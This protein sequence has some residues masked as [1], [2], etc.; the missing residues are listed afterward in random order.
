MEQRISL[1]TLGVSS[2]TES[3]AFHKRLGW[4]AHPTSSDGIVFFQA[5]GMIFGLF[6]RAELAKDA[7]VAD[8]GSIR[9]TE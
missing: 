4:K 7:K 9:L 6:P 3:R 5:G 8:D 2:L 1:V